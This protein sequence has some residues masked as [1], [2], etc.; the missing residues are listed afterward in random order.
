MGGHHCDRLNPER[1]CSSKH[2]RQKPRKQINHNSGGI[3]V[4]LAVRIWCSFASE[5]RIAVIEF[6]F[7]NNICEF[8]YTTYRFDKF[9]SGGKSLGSA[10][11]RLLRSN[12]VHI[13]RVCSG[14]EAAHTHIHTRARERGM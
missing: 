11:A 3:F 4:W 9:M 10:R 5:N 1:L 2:A 7:I 6:I 12:S 8:T 13:F 14:G